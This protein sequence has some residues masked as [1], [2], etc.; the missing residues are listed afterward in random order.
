MSEIKYTSDNRAFPPLK[1]SK[2]SN[3]TKSTAAETVADLTTVSAVTDGAINAAVKDAFDAIQKEHKKLE[4]QWQLKFAKLESKM[5][6]L[7]KSVASDVITAMLK[8][9][10][11]PFLNKTDFFSQ[12]TSQT[13]AMTAIM[14]ASNSKVNEIKTMFTSIQAALHDGPPIPSPPRKQRQRN[15]TMLTELQD[16]TIHPLSPEAAGAQK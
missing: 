1:T 7:S 14:E 10:Q 5:E 8:S 9:D 2:T 16:D 15:E 13:S 11:M 3:D 12:M 4:T 6:D